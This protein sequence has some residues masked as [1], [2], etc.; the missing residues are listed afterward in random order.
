MKRESDP[1]PAVLKETLLL[2]GESELAAGIDR[3]PV[4]APKRREPKRRE[5]EPQ[6]PEHS[7]DEHDFADIAERVAAC[8]ACPLHATRTHPVP[9]EGDPDADLMFVGEGPGRDEDRTGRPF[10]GRAGQLLDRMIAAMGLQRSE[11]F[12]GNVIKCR[13]PDNRT[14]GPDEI[15]ACLPFLKEQIGRISPRVIVAL[16]SPAAKT[17]LDTSRGIT[18]LRGRIYTLPFDESISVVPTFHPAYLLRN[19]AE[20]PSAWKDLQLAMKLLDEVRS[21][22]ERA[23]DECDGK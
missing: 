9:G 21:E 3:L 13:P 5:P 14:P 1:D 8:T 11:V 4:R 22:P 12:I 16:G 17:L 18:A 15:A 10:V 2:H 6:D 7:R 19:E 20:K 23:S